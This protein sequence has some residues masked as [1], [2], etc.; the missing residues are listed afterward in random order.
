MT[1]LNI[2]YEAAQAL[3]RKAEEQ[4]QAG[5][6]DIPMWREVAD[7][8]RNA[9]QIISEWTAHGGCVR[10][11]GDGWMVSYK[12]HSSDSD[13]PETAL[14]DRRT[15][16]FYMLSGDHRTAYEAVAPEGWD[17]LFA[18]YASLEKAYPHK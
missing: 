2:T 13:K 4:L 12:A 10:L 11:A 16:N 18:L 1:D 14:I 8:L 17:A 15:E 7:G 6:N 5:G 9:C 3:F